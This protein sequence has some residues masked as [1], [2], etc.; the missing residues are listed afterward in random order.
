MKTTLQK[1][2]DMN[3]G[4]YEKMTDSLRQSWDIHIKAFGPV[5]ETAFSQ[6]EPSRIQLIGALNHISKCNIQRGM[7]ILKSVRDR[8]ACNEDLI[9]WTFCVGLCF[10]MSGAK[11]QMIT[12]YDKVNAM[13]H[14]FYLPYLK[15]AKAA[16][17][18]G[19]FKKAEPNYR[20]AISC[21]TDEA[22]SK[23]QTILASAYTNLVSCLTMLHRYQEAEEIWNTK[24]SI[25]PGQP[26]SAA[27]AAI[28]YAAMGNKEMVAHY[29]EVL[30]RDFPA[31]VNQTEAMTDAIL[32]G[33]HPAF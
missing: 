25:L 33:E 27:T 20:M 28:L 22:D 10:D 9:A 30:K 23:S 11:Q 2:T 26:G 31:W 14:T 3:E 17:E 19:D 8:C 24:I 18:Q 6:D 15:V 1:I 32:R 21:L 13:G 4:L 12:W 5:L 29:I 7:E 16:H